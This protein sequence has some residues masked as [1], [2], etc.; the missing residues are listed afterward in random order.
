MFN[1]S[2][3]SI[4]LVTLLSLGNASAANAV[5]RTCADGSAG[6]ISSCD[7]TCTAGGDAVLTQCKTCPNNGAPI[8]VCTVIQ[9]VN[10]GCADN[11][12]NRK[13]LCRDTGIAEC[14]TTTISPVSP[15]T[16][17]TLKCKKDGT[18]ESGRISADA[19]FLNNMLG[20]ELLEIK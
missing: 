10:G 6:T 15:G 1:K 16:P 9:I 3:L 20:V 14:G 4:A 7:L 5:A 19:Y 17:W 13:T 2:I 18:P 12:T 11:S 8:T